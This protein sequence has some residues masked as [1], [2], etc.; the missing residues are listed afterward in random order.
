MPKKALNDNIKNRS[1]VF[2][3]ILYPD[4][5]SQQY[6]IEC[7]RKGKYKVVY[8]LHDRDLDEEGNL[9]KPHYHFI[10]RFCNQ[11]FL[12]P[13]AKELQI[14]ENYIQCCSSFAS[15]SCYIIHIDEPLKAQYLAEEVEGNN[16]TEF[17]EAIEK[18]QNVEAFKVQKIIEYIHNH[19]LLS[20]KQLV[21]WC[22]SN[23]F[24]DVLRRCYSIIKDIKLEKDGK[25]W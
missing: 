11:R 6:A 13:V 24:F 10:I 15:Q 17:Y 22:C 21:L 1:C 23:G 4:D 25:I 14:Q 8:I 16:L 12:S 18:K 20:Y 19:E 2:C 7:F 3:G 9:K 5:E